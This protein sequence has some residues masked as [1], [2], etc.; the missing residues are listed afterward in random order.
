MKFG[1]WLNHLQSIK[2]CVKSGGLAAA[3]CSLA[4]S[5]LQTA[6]NNFSSSNLLGEGSFGHVYKARL[7]YDVYAAVKRLTSVGKQPQ[8]ELQVMK[9]THPSVS[10]V[11]SIGDGELP[12]L[13]FTGG[14]N[15]VV[16][17]FVIGRGGSDVQDKTSQ[18]GGSPGLFK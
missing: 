1:P 3:P 11:D 5:L 12:L 8:K 4:Y 10:S 17:L 16:G 18:L 2:S 9:S 13:N 6:T 7:D 15:E 14:G